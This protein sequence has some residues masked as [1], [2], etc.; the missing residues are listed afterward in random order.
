MC[1]YI[2]IFI[3]NGC[4]HSIWKFL[5]QGLNLSCNCGNPGFFNPLGQA[6]IDLVPPQ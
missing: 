4:T 2:Y 5:G 3:F 6:G 1:I